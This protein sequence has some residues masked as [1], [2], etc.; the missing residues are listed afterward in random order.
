MLKK[1][2]NSYSPFVELLA[3]AKR[4]GTK[5]ILV[6]SLPRI[7]RDVM[8]AKRSPSIIP[9]GPPP[10]G[11]IAELVATASTT[12]QQPQQPQ[13]QP[14]RPKYG[15]SGYRKFSDSSPSSSPTAPKIDEVD[16][17]EIASSATA[18]AAAARD[19]A[20]S[21]SSSTPSYVPLKLAMK[22]RYMWPSAPS[23]PVSTK[24]DGDS[25]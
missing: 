20:P 9:R 22:S 3:N 1:E 6:V 11:L 8:P 12:P 5:S 14:Q 7:D 13:Q 10:A 18:A 2:K 25:D 16:D 15:V 21:S 19:V 23:A 24:V 17:V 4:S